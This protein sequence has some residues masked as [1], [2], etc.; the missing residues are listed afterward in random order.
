M[1]Q[2]QAERG[3]VPLV[4]GPLSPAAVNSLLAEIVAA[5]PG[6]HLAGQVSAA[7]GNPF[8]V[9]ELVA[10]LQADG[11]IT[12]TDDGAEIASVALPPAL[13]VTILHRMSFLSSATLDLLRMASIL[14]STFSVRDLTLVMESSARTLA[15]M[16]REAIE[17]GV[18]AET[19][20][21]ITFR[22]DLLREALYEDMPLSLRMSLHHDAA[23]ALAGDGAPTLVVAEHFLRGAVKGDAMAMAWLQRAADE[24]TVQAPAVAA[25]LLNRAIDLFEPGPGR[26]LVMADRVVS[27]DSAGRVGEAEAICV[28]L[29][30]RKQDPR[31]EVRLRLSLSRLFSNSGRLEQAIEQSAQAL[32]IVGLSPAQH[33]RAMANASTLYVWIPDLGRAEEMARQA[34]EAGAQAGDEIACAVSAFT[35][36]MAALRRG[37]LQDAINWATKATVAGD[38]Q[39][40]ERMAQGWQNLRQASGLALV[41][42]LLGSDRFDDADAVLGAVRRATEQFGFKRLQVIAGRCLMIRRF[43]AGEWDDAIAE[44]DAIVDL[45]DEIENP[46]G[47]LVDPASLR[48][49]IA[50]RRGDPT[51]GAAVLPAADTPRDLGMGCWR[52]QARALLAEATGQPDLAT[53]VLCQAWDRSART[54]TA[55]DFPTLGPDVVRL[56][57]SRDPVR[58]RDVTLAV[59]AVAGANPGVATMSAAALRCRGLLDDDADLLLQASAA[60]VDGHWPLEGALACEDSG[61]VAGPK[62]PGP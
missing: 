38:N 23:N 4:L 18:L 32:A 5:T 50:V 19:G 54:E 24:V 31:T 3:S 33:A 49:I 12:T 13:K 14:G 25:D 60:Y 48:A 20:A 1:L 2:T 6:P 62:R 53:E 44:F 7:G 11:S 43:L 26:D 22:H 52:A 55:G 61:R 57:R 35:L 58:A 42:A 36:S 47:S 56:V 27:L 40:E 9:T 45:C 39:P 34:R 30:T 59:C 37:Q 46:A 28:D 51:R 41:S 16:I 17:A 10:A 15:P 21:R 29:L 8:F